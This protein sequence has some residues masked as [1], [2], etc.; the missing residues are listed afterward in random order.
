MKTIDQPSL[1]QLAQRKAAA[2]RMIEELRQIASR[3]ERQTMR[4]I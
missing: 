4:V 2:R 3:I 1:E